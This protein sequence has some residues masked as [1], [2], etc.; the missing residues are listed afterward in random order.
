MALRV[1]VDDHSR[2]QSGPLDHDQEPE[3]FWAGRQHV[4][5]NLNAADHQPAAERAVV[6]LL[7]VP[8][9]LMFPA[10]LIFCL[11]RSDSINNSVIDVLSDLL[12]RGFLG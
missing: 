3:L 1:G 10:I 11:Q 6:L 12:L 5:G 8:Y 7:K 4:D 2:R 9:R